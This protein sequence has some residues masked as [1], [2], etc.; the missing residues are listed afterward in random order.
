MCFKQNYIWISH[1]NLNLC[2]NTDPNPNQ[3][4]I[5]LSKLFGYGGYGSIFKNPQTISKY[6]LLVYDLEHF[7]ILD[8]ENS[9]IYHYGYFRVE[10]YPSAESNKNTP[11]N[12]PANC[13][14]NIS[15]LN[16]SIHWL[17]F[18]SKLII[19]TNWYAKH[20]CNNTSIN[21]P[22]VI[23]MMR[24][25][26][27]NVHSCRFNVIKHPIY[28]TIRYI[29]LVTH[30][31]HI[32][33]YF[34]SNI[35]VETDFINLEGFN[36][37]TIQDFEFT[38]YLDIILY[39]LGSNIYNVGILK[40]TDELKPVTFHRSIAASRSE[41]ENFYNENSSDIILHSFNKYFKL[42]SACLDELDK[43]KLELIHI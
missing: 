42:T 39:S 23:P 13:P 14:K 29:I 24:M 10:K 15:D 11:I 28:T 43:F 37:G 35:L 22:I 31:G 6:K 20:I 1:M 4:S 18:G 16:D 8:S 27:S 7:I 33:L 2:P 26:L 17:L 30:P 25:E 19:G 12:L 9:T 34:E 38:F 3:I 41:P 21:T 5:S 36:F 32:K 40:K